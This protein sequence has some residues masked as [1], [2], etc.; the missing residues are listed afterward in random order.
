MYQSENEKQKEK[1]L[2][3]GNVL[4]ERNMLNREQFNMAF[5][6]WE[7]EEK[8]L[9]EILYNMK[10][11]DEE[12]M[13]KVLSYEKNTEYFPTDYLLKLDIS[14]DVLSFISANDALE[15]L[16]I[17]IEYNMSNDILVITLAYT[18]DINKV[19]EAI[20]D[21]TGVVGVEVILTFE[22][23]IYQ[24]IQSNYP[25]HTGEDLVNLETSEDVYFGADSDEEAFPGI[26]HTGGVDEVLFDETGEEDIIEISSN[27]IEDYDGEINEEENNKNDNIKGRLAD[28]PL[29]D[30]LQILGNNRKTCR[31][32]IVQGSELGEIYL[33]EGQIVNAKCCSD[34]GETAFYDI[35]A[36]EDGYFEIETDIKPDKRII[37]R[38]L[39]NLLLD[40][41]RILDEKRNK[42]M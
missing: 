42:K 25:D 16:A 35:M 19:T 36:W 18:K 32:K 39:E 30:M 33:E 38:T 7:K 13:L 4:I 40:G 8:P 12:D 29:S 1:I 22:Y 34:E 9:A 31:L 41:A 17:P 6:Y 5:S 23:T 28:L 11:L 15:F 2:G 24:M 3:L 37:A 27:V 21:K 26:Y 14:P 10:I 20:K